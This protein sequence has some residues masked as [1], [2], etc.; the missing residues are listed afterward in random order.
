MHAK[1]AAGRSLSPGWFCA[2]LCLL[3][4]VPS[5]CS[6]PGTLVERGVRDQVL[7]RSLSADLTDLDPHLVTGLPG[8]NVTSAL[9]E[10][11]VAE[12][13]VD[14]HPVPGVAERWEISP[15]GLTYLF[16]L[17]A[18]ARWSN[19]AVITAADFA[20]S[21]RRVLTRSLGASNV[22]LLYPLRN[23]EAYY[24]GTV[25][26]FS[27]VGVAATDPLTLRIQLEHPVPSFLSQL[28]HPVWFPVYLPALEKA[29]SPYARDNPW[30]HPENFV[31]NGPFTLR[32]WSHGSLILVEKSPTYWD[33][34]TVRLKAIHFIPAASVDAEERAFRAGQLH[35]TEALPLAKIDTYRRA[36]DP[37][38]R[39]SPFLDTYFYRLNVTRP[40]LNDAKVRRALSLAVDRRVIVD[41]ILR[42][43]QQPAHSFTPPG[44]NPGYAPPALA[45]DDPAAARTLLKEAGYPGGKGLP[46]LEL[47]I[48]ISGNHQ[49]IAEA[50]EAMW[51]RE[52]GVDVR[53]VSMEQASALEQ[54]R[55]L[56]YQILRSDWSADYLDDPLAFLKVF[57][58]DSS[59]N[60]TGWKNSAYDSL[61]AEAERTGEPAPRF[62]LL[63]RAESILL[64]EAPLIP[65][66]HLT[67]IRL[68]HPAVRGWH[69]TLLD[70]HPY[71]HVWLE[72]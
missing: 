51:R 19:G 31:G 22:S 30:T 6:K 27:R 48:N 42:G 5:G 17:R 52:L 44:C 4:A 25:T 46:P 62:A 15:D 53:I 29:G 60:H 1:Q 12:D 11:L 38:L 24:R 18:N 40:F 68:V 71:K 58:S 16:H 20:G 33:A 65:I 34:A 72:P 32:E 3:A 49:L 10:G 21:I 63:Q 28:S 50:V 26:D 55:V 69:P 54:R 7:Y 36:Q 56:G 23:A 41:T 43:Q 35:I 9:F 64:E 47:L 66:Y 57:T 61:L 13:P 70:H 14:L 39:V 2:F 37:A 8:I 67:T 59:D 45:T